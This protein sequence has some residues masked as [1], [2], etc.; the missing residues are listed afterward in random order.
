MTLNERGIAKRDGSTLARVRSV[1]RAMS[2]L[3]CFSPARMYLT[4]G[5]IGSGAE[6]DA[7]TARRLLVTLRDNGV[8]G[9]TPDGR[10]H[11]TMQMMRFASAVPEGRSLREV[12][13]DHLR[14]LAD[15][16]GLTVLLSVLQDGKA[17]CIERQH[18]DSPVQ[19]RWW[20]VGEAMPLNCGAA[21]RL[22][23]AHMPDAE[24]DAAMEAPLTAMTRHSTTN[25]LAL[26][27]QID[28]IR[29]TG[30]SLSTDDVV[31]G[32][33]ALAAPVRGADGTVVGAVSLGGLTAAIV[34][35]GGA[36]RRPL[37]ASLEA[38]CAGIGASLL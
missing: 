27:E 13:Q 10:Y 12:A 18:G 1:T 20:P 37:L 15:T 4:L 31:E 16:T 35:D 24:R 38:A 22:L 29:A 36:P 2:I 26:T 3:K 8:I 28:A 32:L 25:P 21:P 19:V 11:L 30:W 33:S 5:E 6:L 9:Q 7:G 17:I 34:D 14:A 23:L